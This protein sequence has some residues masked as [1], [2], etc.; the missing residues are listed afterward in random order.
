MLI[1]G[2]VV[3]YFRCH[4]GSFNAPIK[5]LMCIVGASVESN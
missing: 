2:A 5:V 3:G 1:G 4:F